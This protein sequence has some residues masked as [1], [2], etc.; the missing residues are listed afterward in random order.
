MIRIGSHLNQSVTY[1]GQFRVISTTWQSTACSRRRRVCRANDQIAVWNQSIEQ[2]ISL[3]R[4]DIQSRRW[5]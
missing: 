3:P 1:V 4:T 2:T 5:T